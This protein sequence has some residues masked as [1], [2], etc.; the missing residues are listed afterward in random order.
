MVLH[1]ASAGA[2]LGA[3]VVQ[4]LAPSLAAQQGAAAAAGWFRIAGALSKRLYMPAGILLLLTGVVLVLLND[5]YGFA[6]PFVTVG[7]TVI[8]IGALLGILVFEP[9]SEV[10]A[11]AVES[12]DQAAIRSATGR[13]G[14]FGTLDT[15]LILV[16]ITAMV[17]RWGA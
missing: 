16:A 1:I 4:A 11:N 14:A 9:G 12:G 13:L 8:V 17:F 5:A 15:I 10:A 2:W 7:F 6:E 3:N